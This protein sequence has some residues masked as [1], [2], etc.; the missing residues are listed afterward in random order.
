MRP[1]YGY[2]QQNWVGSAGANGVADWD[3]GF[4]AAEY[5]GQNT[6]GFITLPTSWAND[7][8][9]GDIVDNGFTVT[10]SAAVGF[11]AIEEDDVSE[12]PF[13]EIDVID[14][15]TGGF[16]GKSITGPWKML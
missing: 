1:G 6:F 2:Q 3:E 11:W 13:F 8:R 4:T 9:S 14:G 5:P 12:P 15:Q 7:W 10:S 16:A